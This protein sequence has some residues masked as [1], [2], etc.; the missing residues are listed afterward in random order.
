MRDIWRLKGQAVAIACVIGGGIATLVMAL[1]AIDSLETTRRAYYAEYRFADIFATAKRA[2]KRSLGEIAAIPGVVRAESRIVQDIILDI[3]GMP[4]PA[5]GRIVSRTA[6]GGALLNDLMIRRGRDLSPGGADEI[7]VN[8]VF[9]RAHGFVPGDTIHG[10]INERRRVLKIV[11]IALSPEYVYAIGPGEIVPDDRRFGVFWMRHD[12]LEAAYGLTGA[13]NDVTV[14]LARNASEADVIARLD[15]IL[16]PYGG[17]GAYGRADQ[18]SDA[19]VTSEMEQ[20]GHFAIVIPPVFLAVAA[21]LFNV[22]VRRLV[23]TER[24]EIGVMKAFGYSNGEVG[25]HYLKLALVIAAL[26]ILVGWGVGAWMGEA[27]TRIYGEFF[28]FPNLHFVIEVGTF[29]VGALVGLLAAM[30]GALG[31]VRSAAALAPAIAM[32]PPAP[33]VYRV[34]IVERMG[35]APALSQSARMILRHVL[36]WP[37]RSSLTVAGIAFSVAILISSLFFLDGVKEMMEIHFFETERQDMSLTFT[38]ARADAV[39]TNLDDLPGVLAVETFRRVPAKIRL[40]HREERVALQGI[41][42]QADLSLLVDIERR[43]VALPP[44]GITL[45]DKL[46]ELLSAREGDLVTVAALE[47]R[48]PLKRLPVARIVHQYVGLSAYMEIAALN[49][50]MGEGPTASGAHI[51]TDSRAEAALYADLKE[52]PA[53]LGLAVR[54]SSFEIFREMIHKHLNTMVFFYVA[55]A[56]LIAVGVVYNSARISLSERARELASL[57]VLGY[58]RREVGTILAGELAL[59]T[60]IALPLGCILGY[61]MA[62]LMVTLFDTKL[63]RVPFV[64]APGTYGYAVLAV[65]GAATVSA[66][67]V[68]RRVAALDLIAVLKTR[69]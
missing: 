39:R 43:V 47:G 21:F 59:L 13:F 19:F 40:G 56:A 60:L 50:F 16:A 45:S 61:A 42:R 44:E 63:Y 12:V 29:L 28:R 65:L 38:E 32:A 57:R 31:A 24:A 54:Q 52:T 17:S 25:W 49:R 66:G 11:G 1:S 62:A 23:Q 53:L 5:R 26:G 7:L 68:L 6:N 46:A 58:T 34:N 55:F 8:D 10:N 67:I 3:A 64:I 9:A 69:E 30:L 4:E 36:R 27:V 22:V 35:I 33:S 37:V 51:L 18:F 41:Q 15:R 20:L 2:P 48:R 14:K